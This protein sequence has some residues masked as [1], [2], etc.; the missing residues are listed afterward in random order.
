MA[1]SYVLDS[2]SLFTLFF[3]DS[4]EG[5]QKILKESYILDLTGYEI[6]SILTKGNDG[7]IKGL[8]REIT[9]DLTKEIEKVVAM[10]RAI[11]LEPLDI[12]EIMKLSLSTGLTFYD[13]SYIFYCKSNQIVLLTDD[14]E[15]Y[16]E[17]SKL[18]LEV[19]KVEEVFN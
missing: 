9:M 18:G 4:E 13:A 16:R 1:S 3:M 15:M 19:K 7:H 6:G 11:K 5:V 2:S 17:A 10:I 12:A 14:K 8:D